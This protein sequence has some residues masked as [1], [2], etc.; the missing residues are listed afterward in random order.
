M[1]K[2]Q[3][4][5]DFLIQCPVIAENPLFFNFLD[6]KDNNKQIITQSNETS[7]NKKFI[8]GSVMKRFTF[9]IVDFRSVIYQPIPKVEGYTN[10]NVEE[11]IDV[12]SIMDWVNA[13]ADIENY[14]DFGNDCK[15][16][17]MRTTSE[18]PNLNG[19]DTQITPALAKYS[20]SIQIDYIDTSKAI[21]K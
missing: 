4:V 11:I 10:E 9:T 6:A 1:D 2:Y 20:M 14:P 15:I 18:N 21:W 7:L 5:I 12:Q 17:S 3:A 16:D 19:V 8:D 13:Q